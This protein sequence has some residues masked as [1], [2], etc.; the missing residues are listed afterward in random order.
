MKNKKISSIRISKGTSP[1]GL[2]RMFT[3]LALI[4]LVTIL[5][6]NGLVVRKIYNTHNTNDAKYAALNVSRILFEQKKELLFLTDSDGE[7]SLNVEPEHV[8]ELDEYVRAYMAPFEI[9]K[10]KIFSKNKR[11]V[12]STDHSIIGKIDADNEELKRALKGE[13]VSRI[14]KKDKIW[15]L[16]GEEQYDLEIA[17]TYLPVWD[18]NIIVGSFEIYID[19]SRSKSEIRSILKSSLVVFAVVMILAL[20]LL[21][22]LMRRGTAQLSKNEE[23]LKESEES[24]RSVAE[25][26]N[27]A[28]IS[29]DSYGKIIFW[30]HAAENIFGHAAEE[31]VGRLVTFI[32]PEGFQEDHQNGLE[33]FIKT[34]KPKVIGKMVELVG[35]KKDGSEFPLEITISNWNAKDE[36]VF[37]AIIRDITVRRQA[38]QEKEELE[39]QLRQ[40]Q[41]MESIGKLA[42]GIAHDFNNILSPI[43]IHSE[44]AMMDLSPDNP[45]NNNLKEI[46]KAGERARDMVTQILTFSRQKPQGRTPI[47]IGSIL[48]EV[49][50]L[51]RASIPTTIEI[52]HNLETEDDTVFADPTQLHQVI[53]NLCTNASHAMREKGGV[54]DI[55]LDDLDLDSEAVSQFIGLDPGSYVRLTVSDTGQGIDPE[56]INRIFEPYFTTKDPGEGT[57]MGLSVVHGIVKSHDGDI[58]V[59]SELGKGT[60]FRILFP[61]IESEVSPVAE[62]EANLPRGNDRILLVDDEKAAVDAIQPMLENLGYK[63]TAR[64]SSVEC[65]EAFR[66]NPG[67]FDIVITDM[68]MPN[69][70]GKDLAKELMAIRPDIPIILCTGFSELI[71]KTKAKEMGISAFVMKPIVMSQM[72][73]T[74]RKVLD[75]PKS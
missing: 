51:L 43:M 64:T 45:I 9:M 40:S 32:M 31:A 62:R 26:A 12:Y 8:A 63:V 20:G 71:D 21:Y 52:R 47:K 65:L 35:L 7:R 28:I 11:I 17:E 41:K 61:T 75:D 53:V 19:I 72:A 39:E 44:M 13:V 16:A 6:L 3:A 46:Y 2:L 14:D 42:G 10:I 49:T 48:N 24:F 1:S 22:I 67:G 57:G 56:V 30:N 29:I 38:E 54:L 55:E 68:T 4:L 27:D 66:N 69:M 70:T 18:N 37:T 23:L 74:I 34:G 15:D 58:S 60:T 5:L 50:K 59:E 33:R 25:T 36:T 73:N